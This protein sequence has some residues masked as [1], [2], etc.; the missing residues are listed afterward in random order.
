[1]N[2]ADSE[3]LARR[4]LA[5]G[6]LEDSL[7]RADVAILNTCVVRQASEDRVYSKLHELKEW[8][9]PDRTIAVTGCIVAKEG[10]NLARR[11]PHLDA[12]VPIG[13][14]EAF[15]ANLEARYDYSQGEPL[16]HA[17]RTGVSHYVRVIQGCDHNCTFCIVPRVRGREVHVPL[18]AVLAECRHAVADG[19]KE[20]VLVGQN[21]DDYHD[22]DGLGGLAALVR[23]VEQIPG[24][25]RLRFMTSHPQD[26]EPELLEV[27]A[28]SDVVCRELQLPIQSGD[29]MVLRRMARG[30]QTRHYRGIVDNARRLMP[31][32]GLVTDVI[33]GF[34]G[35][36]EA[37]YLNTRALVEDMQ[38]DV[39]HIAMYSPRPGTYAADRMTDDVP[40][41]EKLRR[42]NDLLALQ[43]E[44]AARKTA[45]WIGR[46]AEVLIEGRDELSRPYGRI[47]QGKRANV[48]QAGEIAPGDVVNIRVLQATAGQ[49]TGL[50][51]PMN[52][53]PAA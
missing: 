32:I 1:M 22:P 8:K 9:T 25:K 23:Q 3:S 7:E 43:R 50:L 16:P 48:L 10:E 6:Y 11:F 13:D 52:S 24:L 4:L 21:V 35:E 45:L 51:V 42:L 28:A 12:V 37:A 41:P 2:S 34:P 15:V 40:Q 19:A 20:V 39:V 38:F 30:Y 17:G 18:P 29:D 5:A 26:L 36:T 47:R 44:I 31:D 53:E 33:V 27:M 49:L 14:Y 46:N